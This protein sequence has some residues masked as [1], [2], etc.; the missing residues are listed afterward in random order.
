[1]T[2]ADAINFLKDM[3]AYQGSI[4]AKNAHIPN[5]AA[6]ATERAQKLA[7]VIELLEP[8]AAPKQ[9]RLTLL[10]ED[11]K[12]LPPELLQELSVTKSDFLD[13]EIVEIID[14]A[15]GVLTLDQII[16]AL[17]RKTQEVHE[18]SKLNSRM[19]RMAKKGLVKSLEG[20]KGVYATKEVIIDDLFDDDQGEETSP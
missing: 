20:R 8:S 9:P 4:A 7:K 17:Y 19:Y 1:M 3:Q 11:L 13:F 18:R 16:I 2:I 15:G 12:D 14:A 5:R 6:G 10:P